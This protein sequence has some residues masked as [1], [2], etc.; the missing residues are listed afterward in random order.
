MKHVFNFAYLFIPA[1]ILAHFMH[2]SETLIFVLAAI[3]IL[4]LAKLM[5]EATEHLSEKTGPG[6]GGF[7]NATFG[8]ATELI[9]ALAAL[10]KGL[11]EVVRASITGAIVGNILFV[12]GVSMIAGGLKFRELS[13][14]KTSSHV[15]IGMLV[16]VVVSLVAPGVFSSIGGSAVTEKLHGLSLFV[17]FVL[18]ATY[19]AYLVFSL[20]THKDIFVPEGFDTEEGEGHHDG[21]SIKKSV[22]MLVLATIGVAIVSELLIGS[23]EHVGKTF[24]FTD[25]F[26]GV[27]VLAILGNAAEHSTAVLVAM[28]NKMDLA[29]QIA[30]GSSIQVAM[31]VAPILVITATFVFGKPLDLVFH[32]LEIASIAAST[33]IAW[34]VMQDGKT[35]WLEG[36]MLVATYLIFGACFYLI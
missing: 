16:I 13:F 6:I 2:A 1:A 34:A 30:V 19:V 35:N 24:G 33:F 10:E 7:L 25:M 32:P 3:G 23:V 12:L 31:L 17:S 18:L 15:G 21:W 20:K 9:L 29:I 27:F 4:P 26:L 36:V 8:N 14:G 11:L 28:K 22:T 5:G